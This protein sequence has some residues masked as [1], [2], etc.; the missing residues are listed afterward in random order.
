MRDLF[1]SHVDE[2]A[3]LALALAMH[4]E[5][6][7]YSTW[8]F[9]LDNAGDYV[10]GI[11]GAVHD[12]QGML[13]LVSPRSLV[14]QDQVARE[15]HLGH[16]EGKWF[17]PVLYGLSAKEWDRR[18]P[19]TWREAFGE[20]VRVS[21]AESRLMAA[22][23]RIHKSLEARGIAT[24][25]VDAKRIQELQAEIERNGPGPLPG[26]RTMLA[27]VA[28]WRARGSSLARKLAVTAALALAL[29]ALL[30]VAPLLHGS[31][32]WPRSRNPD[33]TVWIAAPELSNIDADKGLDT[34]REDY[35]ELLWALDDALEKIVAGSH[36]G[37]D[38]RIL[39]DSDID[40]ELLRR[41][42]PD[43]AKK[44]QVAQ[45][46][47]TVAV[48]GLAIRARVK[49]TFVGRSEARLLKLAIGDE[50]P[51]NLRNRQ[52]LSPR[53]ANITVLANWGAE[54]IARFLGIDE[55]TIKSALEV[56]KGY[57]A[58]FDE[59]FAPSD[60][61]PSPQHTP[62]P[63]S[64]SAPGAPSPAPAA[65]GR[66]SWLPSLV[67]TAFAQQPQ[68]ADDRDVREVLE[69]LRAALESRDIG[70]VSPLFVAMPA[71]Q[72]E[73]LQHYFAQVTDLRVA[74]GQPDITLNGETAAASFL[75][76]D[77]FRDRETK[78]PVRIAIRL[79][80]MLA[81]T[82]GTWKIRSLEKPS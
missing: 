57:S 2:D 6:K 28:D 31:L 82:N 29:A 34:V 68:A 35:E 18:V 37:S 47:D 73:S 3:R 20:A 52:N 7:G 13:V 38:L 25:A 41:G 46:L 32:R 14:N 55:A 15:I 81:R 74:F 49:P 75:R 10:K 36:L 80:A 70:Q 11:R 44:N 26:R 77:E 43:T 24:G 67:G 71:A 50:N 58:R 30:A 19:P 23:D 53:D 76:R 5:S 40:K 79:V 17:I 61:S 4:L 16:S 21:V 72:Q 27:L 22:T 1:V 78:E 59:Q 65:P 39:S 12:A 64:Q 66:T 62:P 51:G 8:C 9:E 69:R 42:C 60:P 54:E 63:P 45:C 56:V 48:Q 33:L